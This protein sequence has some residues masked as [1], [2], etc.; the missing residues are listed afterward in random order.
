MF[1]RIFHNANLALLLQG[2]FVT[3]LGNHIQDM[4][5]L[6]WLKEL[7]GSATLM[8]IALLLTNLPEAVLAPIGGRIADRI[9]S[10]R[11][12]T[13]SDMVAGT[14]VGFVVVGIII[15]ADT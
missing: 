4:A 13:I 2:Q 15:G 11:A 14:A 10:V 8:G 5:V 9:G 1:K 12:M 7:T 6:L 3:N